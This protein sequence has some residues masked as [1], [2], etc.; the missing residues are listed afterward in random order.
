MIGE[1]FQTDA[2]LA[3][4]RVNVSAILEPDCDGDGFGDETQDSDLSSCDPNAPTATITKGP[5]DKTKK[6]TATF[7][8]SGTDTRAIAGFQCSV[9]SAPFATCTSPHTVKVKKGK[10]TFEVRAVD[11]AGNVGRPVSD[12]WKVKKKTKK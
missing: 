5:K 10:H 1:S 12:A 4:T 11:L 7:E 8:F 3:A 9:D 2:S 6:K